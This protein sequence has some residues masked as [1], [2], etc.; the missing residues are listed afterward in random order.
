MP[1][2]TIKGL[3]AAAREAGA[4]I[5]QASDESAGHAAAAAPAA[6]RPAPAAGTPGGRK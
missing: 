4:A 2:T 1:V 5:G 6:G 3:L